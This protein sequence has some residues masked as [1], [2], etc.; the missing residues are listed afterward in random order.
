MESIHFID[1]IVMALVGFLIIFAGKRRY[2]SW[3]TPRSNAAIRINVWVFASFA[4]GASLVRPDVISS[5]TVS[6]SGQ[7]FAGFSIVAGTMCAFFYFHDD[8]H[9]GMRLGYGL[10]W[11][12]LALLGM[13]IIFAALGTAPEPV[14]S[15]MALPF[16]CLVFIAAMTLAGF[17]HGILGPVISSINVALTI[18]LLWQSQ[19]IPTASIYFNI[20]RDF[21]LE[22]PFFGTVAIIGST[23]LGLTEYIRNVPAF[24]QRIFSGDA[25]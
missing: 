17:A 5:F 11:S 2:D 24:L 18:G 10:G 21:G 15:T 23:L 3:R 13:L 16:I 6:P 1:A 9:P 4:L 19:H 22:S 12:I 7:W 14:P 20:L 8:P 25:D